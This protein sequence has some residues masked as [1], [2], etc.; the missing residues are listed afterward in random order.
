MF[1][2]FD[3][4]VMEFSPHT[5]GWTGPLD[6]GALTPPV[7]PAHAGMDRIPLACSRSFRGFP[8]TRGDGPDDNMG[9]IGPSQFSPHTRGWTALAAEKSRVLGVFPAHAGMDRGENGGEN[10]TWGFP[11]TRGDGPLR[12]PIQDHLHEF[13]PHTRGWTGLLRRRRSPYRVFPAHAGMDRAANGYA[14]SVCCFP[15][16]RGDGPSAKSCPTPT[17]KFSPHT[18]GWTAD[19]MGTRRRIAVFPAHAGMDRPT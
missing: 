13:S 7:F 16:T 12:R 1:G 8:R 18:R 19:I 3:S 5:R 2:E 6:V 10:G 9:Q 11:R 14:D 15:R 4:R 17:H